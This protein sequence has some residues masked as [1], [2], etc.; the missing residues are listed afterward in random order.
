MLIYDKSE[1]DTPE[2]IALRGTINERDNEF[3]RAMQTHNKRQQDDCE[4]YNRMLA[5]LRPSLPYPAHLE[6]LRLI[7]YLV[8]NSCDY[9]DHLGYPRNIDKE[10]NLVLSKGVQFNSTSLCINLYVGSPYLAG[11]SARRAWKFTLEEVDTIRAYLVSLDLSVVSEWAH[12]DGHAFVVAPRHP[13]YW[14]GA[15]LH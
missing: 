3:R 12:D 2:L 7:A 10:R 8:H 9:G 11:A 14:R 1:Y 4:R 13:T 5:D 6:G 15:V